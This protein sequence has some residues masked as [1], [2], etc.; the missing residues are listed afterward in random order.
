MYCNNNTETAL[1]AAIRGK[2]YDIA[3]AL[4]NAGASPN[5]VIKPYHNMNEV[6][7]V[8]MTINFSLGIFS[9]C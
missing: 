9:M 5:T 3:L 2:H 7:L 8:L 4:L 1:H 6:R